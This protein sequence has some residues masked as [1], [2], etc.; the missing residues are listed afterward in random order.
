MEV[1]SPFIVYRVSVSELLQIQTGKITH[2]LG[3]GLASS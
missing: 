3:L 2:I 1:K